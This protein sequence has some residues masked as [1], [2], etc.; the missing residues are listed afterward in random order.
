MRLTL[1]AFYTASITGASPLFQRDNSGTS[2]PASG[3]KGPT[4]KP[5]W[6]ATYNASVAAGRIPSSSPSY[7][8]SNGAVK[9]GEGVETGQG[10]RCTDSRKRAVNGCF[11]TNDV[12]DAPDGMFAVSFD[13]GP[14]PA[15]P[16]LYSFLRESNQTAT[17]FFIGSNIL[18]NPT[19]F[20]QAVDMGGHIAVH[21]WSHP[22]MTTLTDH[23]ILGELGWTIQLI[24]DRSGRLP[25]WWRPP[26]GDADNRVRAIAE[27][28]FGLTLVGWNQDSDD[29]CLNAGGGSS[30]GSSGPTSDSD[31]LQEL[32][33]WLSGSKAPGLLPLEHEL[34]SR[35]VG[36]FI[37]AYSA[38]QEHGWDTRCVPDLFDE[39]WYLNADRR[40]A[41]DESFEVGAGNASF[42]DAVASSAAAATSLTST[43][44]A[45][46][47]SSTASAAQQHLPTSSSS[48]SSSGAKT[49]RLTYRTLHNLVVLAAAFI[50]FA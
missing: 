21:T 19:I 42:Y 15:S 33:G 36:A 48:S 24:Y 34:T 32:T 30:C 3:T 46:S 45:A 5:E 8:D 49:S 43:A 2:Y 41:P 20:D 18:D 11:G 35:S 10:G 31:L 4:P 25:A 38:V 27:E 50:F 13:D 7:L 26:Y 16:T 40:E 39:A 47:T 6:V 14:L 28:V 29:W 37:K 17:H 12:Y 9:Y 1:L 44:P 23:Q 22:Y